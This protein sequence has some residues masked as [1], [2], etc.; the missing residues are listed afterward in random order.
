MQQVLLTSVSDLPG[1][2][3]RRTPFS[4]AGSLGWRLKPR[5][6]E[7][8]EGVFHPFTNDISGDDSGYV[9]IFGPRNEAELQVIWTIAQISYYQA[10]GLSMDP[11]SSTAVIPIS[12][13]MIKMM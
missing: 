8:P 13:A 7:G 5:F 9:M 12:L 2:R 11:R 4:L 6:A 1:I 3:I 10:R